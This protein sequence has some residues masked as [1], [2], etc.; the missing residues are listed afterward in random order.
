MGKNNRLINH[1][2]QLHQTFEDITPAIY[3]SIVLALRQ[4]YG[5]G[6][7]RINRVLMASQKIW[8]DHRSDLEGM[9][10][11]CEDEVGIIIKRG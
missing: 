6:H 3:A 1:Y 7:K 2:K 10:K 11:R 5:W 8:E 4:E 9:C